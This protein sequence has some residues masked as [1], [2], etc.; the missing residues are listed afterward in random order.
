MSTSGLHWQR[1]D[2][3]PS[4]RLALVRQ[5]S[6][7][8][9]HILPPDPAW[10]PA[11][12][13]EQARHAGGCFEPA[14]GMGRLSCFAFGPASWLLSRTAR[15]PG[16]RAIVHWGPV[17]FAES[18]DR[19]LLMR[20]GECRSIDPWN[21]RRENPDQRRRELPS[22]GREPSVNNTRLPETWISVW[23]LL[24]DS[25]RRGLAEYGL[26]APGR[27]MVGR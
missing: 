17:D 5:P 27:R 15:V 16:N 20:V 3:Y 25:R 8:N 7:W 4:P 13:D 22:P 9:A 6:G 11:F 18:M 2:T 21:V 19:R 14:R 1:N 23:T 26:D 12:V 10:F 24:G